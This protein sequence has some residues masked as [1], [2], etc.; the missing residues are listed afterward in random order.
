ML[1]SP[2]PLHL[3]SFSPLHYNVALLDGPSDIR[4]ALQ[5]GELRVK[6]ARLR[7]WCQQP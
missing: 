4:H 6:H 5:T 7:Y 1:A 2:E 3:H